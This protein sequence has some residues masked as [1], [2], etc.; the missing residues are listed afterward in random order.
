MIACFL[1][2]SLSA[3]IRYRAKFS[4]IVGPGM[5]DHPAGLMIYALSFYVYFYA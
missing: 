2:L 5:E 4:V 1:L 3:F